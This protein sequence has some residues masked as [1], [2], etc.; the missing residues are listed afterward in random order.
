MA[1]MSAALVFY[2]KDEVMPTFRVGLIIITIG[3]IMVVYK[4][5]Q[6]LKK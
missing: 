5:R 4:K 2:Y 1:F 3:F 6:Q